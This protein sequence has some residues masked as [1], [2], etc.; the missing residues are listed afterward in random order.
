MISLLRT[1]N[2]QVDAL[3]FEWDEVKAKE[4]ARKHG[5]TFDEARTVFYDEAAVEFSDPDHSDDEASLRHPC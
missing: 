2:V 4:N 3:R 1:Y 5:V